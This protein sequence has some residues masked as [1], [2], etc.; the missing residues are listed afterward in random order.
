[1]TI[2]ETWL[3]NDLKKPV[4]VERLNGNLFSADNQGNLIGVI[5]TDDGN[6]AQI[7]GETTG[8]IIRDDGKT[9]VVQ[10]TT[11]GN[12]ASII[13]P[14]SCYAVIGSISIV[15]KVGRTTVGACTGHV[16]RTSTEAI[17]DPGDVVPSIDELLVKLAVLDNCIND[18]EAWAVGQRNGADVAEDDPTWHNN[19]KY[20]AE[21]T[22]EDRAATSGAEQ[23]VAAGVANA[24]AAAEQARGYA[25]A[26][27]AAQKTAEQAAAEA[28]DTVVAA[29][30]PGILYVGDDGVPYVLD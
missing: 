10:G 4:K 18:S 29:Q 27:E 9:V 16:Y 21:K 3:K 1:M 30:G 17:V 6:T 13:L 22:A 24:Q 12:R 26:A 8:Y 14:E 7:E 25:G 5:I 2:F 28:T 20:Y 23:A 11:D 15:I 19:A